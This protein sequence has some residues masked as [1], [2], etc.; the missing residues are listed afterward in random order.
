M[1]FFPLEQALEPCEGHYLNSIWKL[2]KHLK[3][4]ENF[5]NIWNHSKTSETFEIIRKH[6][7]HF[8]NNSETIQ[9]SKTI[10]ND[11]HNAVETIPRGGKLVHFPHQKILRLMILHLV[12][13]GNTYIHTYIQFVRLSVCLLWCRGPVTWGH[14]GLTGIDGGRFVVL[15]FVGTNP[16]V[17]IRIIN[18]PYIHTYVFFLKKQKAMIKC[19][20]CYQVQIRNDTEKISIDPCARMRKSL[21]TLGWPA[22]GLGAISKIVLVSLRFVSLETRFV[23]FVSFR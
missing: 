19:S 15:S 9:R 1:G 4:F 23:S 5:W 22:D 21:V 18:M 13:A 12:I 3:S 6:V 7:W 17:F 16:N 14:Q 2:L 11:S 8:F 20:I 10:E